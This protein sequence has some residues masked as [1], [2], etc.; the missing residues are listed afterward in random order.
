VLAHFSHAGV[1]DMLDNTCH[2]GV[3]NFF[4]ANGLGP[5]DSTRLYFPGDQHQMRALIA[6]VFH[7]SGLRFVFSTRSSLPDI[8]NEDGQPR[9]GAGYRFEPGQDDVLREGRDGWIV[10]Y[11]DVLCEALD[12]VT[13]L[14]QAG[15]DVG[16]VNKSSLNVVDEACLARVGKG[17]FVLV[18]E[19][20]NVHT[21]LGVRYGSWLLERG[22]HPRYGRAG[23]HLRGDGGSIEQMVQQGLDS[24]SLVQSVKKLSS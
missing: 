6:R 3:N 19:T 5:A 21:G 9:Y 24:A 4:A 16:L 18:A 2:F 11:G 20:Q 23:T 10:T 8:L 7:D 12:A 15:L 14:R 13:E 22:H 17:R 1:A